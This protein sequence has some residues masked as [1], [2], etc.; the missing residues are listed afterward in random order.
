MESIKYATGLRKLWLRFLSLFQW[1]A[2]YSDRAIYRAMELGDIVIS[3]FHPE[4]MGS[5][6]YDLHLGN[7]LVQYND[8]LLDSK[9]DNPIR[10]ITIPKE[11][12]TLKKGEF[13]LG[14][15]LEHTKSYKCVPFIDGKSSTGRLGIQLH[16]TAGKG[17]AG[18]CGQW[19]L[20]I[21]VAH[22]V[23]VYPGMPIGQIF[24]FS[25]RGA[26]KNSYDTKDN[27]K[28]AGQKGIISSRMHKNFGK[29]PIWKD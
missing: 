27:A 24:Y 28:Y 3:P 22:D 1:G 5:N 2:L 15:T 13:Y 16:F 9:K 26:V 10:T 21:A 20:E 18:F 25:L 19:T 29:D 14:T 8:E 6:S 7:T 23:I 11:G 17:D 12:Y 4:C